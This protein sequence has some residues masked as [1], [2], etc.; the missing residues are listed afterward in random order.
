MKK[1]LIPLSLMSLALIPTGCNN[2]G[3]VNNNVAESLSK[4]LTEMIETT[5]KVSNIDEN[6]LIIDELNARTDINRDYNN[7]NVN[8][9]RPVYRRNYQNGIV[10]NWA[11]YRSTN[12]TNNVNNASNTRRTSTRN[13]DR[14][15]RPNNFVNTYNRYNK[16]TNN[17]YGGN[18]PTPYSTNVNKNVYNSTTNSTTNNGVRS[19]DNYNY[20]NVNSSSQNY[21]N[22][23]AGETNRYYTSQYLP[24]YT[25]TV[26]T[27]NS[28]LTN[29][30]EKI[31]DLYTICNDT[32]AASNDLEMLK[33]E[34]I[35]SC[36]SCNEL[37]GKVKTG[38]VTLTKTQIETLNAYNNTLQSC[39][40]DLK[41]C[42]DCNEDINMINL[43][44]GNFSNNCDTLVAKYLK[45]LNNIDTN[46]SYCNNAKCTVSEINNYINS[47]CGQKSVNNGYI[48]RYYYPNYRP[49][50]TPDEY[51]NGQ[52]STNNNNNN[53]SSNATNNQ[54]GLNNNTTN[55]N[56]TN[57]QNATSNNQSVTNNG[58]NPN[59]NVANNTTSSTSQSNST[60]SN[61]VNNVT[62]PSTTQNTTNT[63]NS[64]NTVNNSNRQNVNQNNNT[65]NGYT[66]NQMSRPVIRPNINHPTKDIKPGDLINNNSNANKPMTLPLTDKDYN[67]TNSS[68]NTV[69]N[70]FVSARPNKSIGSGVS[71]SVVTYGDRYANVK[72]ATPSP[73]VEYSAVSIKNDK[74]TN[75]LTNAKKNKPM[76]LE[77]QANLGPKNVRANSP[78][79][80]ELI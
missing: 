57:N 78:K 50:R 28:T 66:G 16:K 41:S 24:R 8:N 60:S 71:K 26:A 5:K 56:A 34:L 15:Y 64:S 80:L 61:L 69:N 67:R 33:D 27:S 20:P 29:Y 19:T 58:S 39:I 55:P 72:L 23:T 3:M 76:T 12:N 65:V 53:S 46:N 36:S 77:A 9:A 42:K 14:V 35:S 47:I 62:R 44:K 59:N 7:E 1:L 25:D 13:S 54:N 32:C 40:S 79:T 6:K 63:N 68:N 43:L 37:L 51:N 45:V 10:K 17:T 74:N 2:A 18:T 11:P 31:Q 38:E 52:N 49:N 75:Y 70:Q 21:V 73:K 4:N 30:L 48:S 22:D